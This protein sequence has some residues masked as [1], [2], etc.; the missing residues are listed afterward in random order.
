MITSCILV[1]KKSRCQ[2][3]GTRTQDVQDSVTTASTKS[4]TVPNM[5]Q[6]GY[7]C[8]DSKHTMKPDQNVDLTHISIGLSRLQMFWTFGGTFFSR[9]GKLHNIATHN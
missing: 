4:N 9:W 3:T 6:K 7:I 1:T 5:K 2:E 8:D